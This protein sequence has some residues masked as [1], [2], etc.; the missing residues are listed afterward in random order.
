MEL[1]PFTKAFQIPEVLVSTDFL[2]VPIKLFCLPLDLSAL[3][4]LIKI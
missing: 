3:Q 4:D 1:R 2:K